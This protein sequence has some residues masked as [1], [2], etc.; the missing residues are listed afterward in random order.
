MHGIPKLVG[1]VVNEPWGMS[2]PQFLAAYWL[3]LALAVGYAL[4]S[5][6][7]MRRTRGSAPDAG[8]TA[9]GLHE[10]AYLAGG[11]RRVAEAAVA[12]LVEAGALRPARRGTVQVVRTDTR[13]ADPVDLAVLTTADR[14]GTP[15]VNRLVLAVA[16]QDVLAGVRS[17]LVAR[18]LLVEPSVARARLRLAVA[19]LVVLLVVGLARCVNGILLDRPVGWLVLQLMLTATLVVLLGRRREPQRTA[20][21]QQALDETRQRHRSQGSAAFAADASL[22]A[23]AGGLVA[24]GG[25]MAFPDNDIRSALLPRSSSGWS[26]DGGAGGG[27]SCGGG[28]AGCGG[29]GGG[30]GGCGG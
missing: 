21:G 23:G 22:A 25:L 14:L 15:A 13:V 1:T 30:G 7:L 27:A 29:G 19:P 16:G 26:G 28:G 11:P 6:W 24:L 17:R 12:R 2:G 10:V 20:R 18:G 4:A 3:V 5:R 9:L 8:G